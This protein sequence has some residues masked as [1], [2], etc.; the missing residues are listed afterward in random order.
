MH[1]CI[2]TY[3]IGDYICYK[4]TT[5]RKFG[6]ILVILIENNIEKLKIQ[7]LLT[8]NE[9]PEKFCNVTRQQRSHE[10]AFWLLDR[11]EYGAIILLEPQAIISSIAI[12]QEDTD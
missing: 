12:G 5:E 2:V 3:R 7:R 1:I 11:D 4:E 8:Y 6:R 10:D 9:L